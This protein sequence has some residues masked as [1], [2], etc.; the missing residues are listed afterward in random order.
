MASK[1]DHHI[2]KLAT[3]TDSLSSP[4]QAP[5]QSRKKALWPAV[6]N[7]LRSSPS[8]NVS[9]A[10]IQVPDYCED[11]VSI[12]S[13]FSDEE[14]LAKLLAMIEHKDS[15]LQDYLDASEA[16]TTLEESVE[17]NEGRDSFPFSSLNEPKKTPEDLR[18][19][20]DFVSSFISFFLRSKFTHSRRGLSP[21]IDP[22][23]LIKTLA[24]NR[25]CPSLRL[26][27]RVAIDPNLVAATLPD[28]ESCGYAENGVAVSQLARFMDI[29]VLHFL[30]T[31]NEHTDT[32]SILWA[33][34]YLM[35]LLHSLIS[36]MNTLNSFGWYGAPHIRIRKATFM[37]GRKS[38]SY[39]LQPPMILNP[40]PVVVVMGTPPG[41]P[42]VLSPVHVGTSLGMAADGARDPV[43][44]QIPIH[45]Q[46]PSLQVQSPLAHET[47]GGSHLST[48]QIS[49]PNRLGESPSSSS[50]E[51]DGGE[52]ASSGREEITTTS[53]QRRN[54]RPELHGIL[55]TSSDPS[56]PSPPRSPRSLP[57]SPSSGSPS[58]SS[59]HHHHHHNPASPSKRT[60]KV[61]PH[62]S[63]GVHPRAV[64]GS[65]P[66]SMQ[67]SGRLSSPPPPQQGFGSMESI[68]EEGN[69]VL[70]DG[71]VPG[72][73]L[74][75]LPGSSERLDGES[76]SSEHEEKGLVQMDPVE[77]SYFENVCEELE[78]TPP[79]LSLNI[80]PTSPPLDVPS[81]SPG[82]QD[83]H[84]HHRHH[85]QVSPL[86]SVSPAPVL[87][88]ILEENLN[89]GA[90]N[91]IVPDHNG[92]SLTS[93]PLRSYSP[94]VVDS[95][96]RGLKAVSFSPPPSPVGIPDVNIDLELETL[97]NGEGRI[98]LI[99]IL[100]AIAKF[101][102]SKDIWTE[103]VGQKC[104]SLIQ[105]CMDV[106]LPPQKD[107]TLPKKK[108]APYER[109]K[110]LVR[111][112]NIACSTTKG[113]GAG[114][115]P[116]EERAWKVHSK[117]VVEF[118]VNALIQ[119]GTSS[120]VGCSADVN[121][122]RLKQFSLASVKGYSVHGKLVHNM[123]RIQ[124]H[125]PAIFRQALVKFA[126]PSFSSCRKLFHFLH[127]FLQYCVHSI[128]EVHFNQLL[129]S[130]V[131]AVLGVVVDR[132]VALDITEPSIQEVSVCAC[133]CVTIS[134]Q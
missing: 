82:H 66:P 71:G 130:T 3:N 45:H 113:P 26:F 36:S 128:Q 112:D 100:H 34:D 68:R 61:T 58:S 133:V 102:Q 93:P 94:P 103:E 38:M 111:Q 53:K 60:R 57:H 126:H 13:S 15:E 132:M 104:F 89:Q 52:A 99:A 51:G 33:L 50:W 9:V 59:Q 28:E 120:I 67:S 77:R 91:A 79:P 47:R 84:P 98:S 12:H 96:R 54:S 19:F 74:E 83:H 10:N 86:H 72:M 37:G 70:E 41:T 32:T 1:P 46:H 88:S 109:R 107:D 97:I 65:S 122:C 27:R 90:S 76:L 101:P 69:E 31:I 20:Q 121:F 48:H 87:D 42:P 95:E 2:H 73:D 105:L 43:T 125:S 118:S 62:S 108:P 80:H 63:G 25:S 131:S 21:D 119:C 64:F 49:I 92:R 5:K 4:P 11:H 24:T 81:T 115:P 40:P 106:G 6:R 116:V 117:H 7:V 127:V 129:A 134:L 8:R 22:H 17:L 114:A 23:D 39:P 123:R 124:L 35:N 16:R 55:K 78:M 110:K 18:H 75:P 56:A 14:S 30:S 85:R 44:G 29:S